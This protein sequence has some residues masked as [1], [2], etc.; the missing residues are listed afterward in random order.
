MSAAARFETIPLVACGAL[1]SSLA[2]VSVTLAKAT[3]SIPV[4]AVAGSI[5]DLK[6]AVS[7]TVPEAVGSVPTAAAAPCYP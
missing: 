3:G 6:V 7:V 4:A 2:G 5:T 1:E